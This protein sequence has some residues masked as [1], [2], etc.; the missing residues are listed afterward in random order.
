MTAILLALSLVTLPQEFRVVDAPDCWTVH[1][2]LMLT[3]GSPGIRIW[4]VGTRRLLGVYPHEDMR[5][6]PVNIRPY[7]N[8]DTNIYADFRV[9]PLA[10]EHR[11]AMRPVSVISA[12]SVVIEGRTQETGQTTV[13]KL[14]ESPK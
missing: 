14:K 5:G 12:R 10:P 13:F 2:R 11:G 7:A 6:L 4:P 1:G 8:W 9:C 3:N